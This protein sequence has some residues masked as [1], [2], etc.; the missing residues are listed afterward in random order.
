MSSQSLNNL[1]ILIVLKFCMPIHIHKKKQLYQISE[2]SVKYFSS[3]A[4]P[5]TWNFTP[6]IRLER[7]IA[8]IFDQVIFELGTWA[9]HF[10]KGL[11]KHCS[12]DL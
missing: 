1:T 9:I 2:E 4:P 10:W 5:K 8:S 12:L 3:Y 11:I 6:E 7:Y